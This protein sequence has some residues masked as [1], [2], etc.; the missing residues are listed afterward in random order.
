MFW[1]QSNTIKCNS[2]NC[3]GIFW[4]KIHPLCPLLY[5]IIWKLS[6][7][8][9]LFLYYE[10][11]KGY[12]LTVLKSAPG[13]NSKCFCLKALEI[14]L[15]KISISCRR[16]LLSQ[17]ERYTQL[18]WIQD[19]F[20][21][22]YFYFSLSLE[23]MEWMRVELSRTVTHFLHLQMYNLLDWN[24]ELLGFVVFSTRKICIT[25]VKRSKSK[26]LNP[27]K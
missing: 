7:F 2:K 27:N 26:L 21:R 12:L 25:V 22:W 13:Q 17:Q 14:P 19:I 5:R 3:I 6:S 18:D 4:S 8:E 16:K 24:L 11:L 1:V 23:E 9:S 20:L 15:R 10:T